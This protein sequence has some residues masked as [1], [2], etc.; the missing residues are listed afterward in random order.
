MIRPL[1][2]TLTLFCS[3]LYFACQSE[4][5][6]LKTKSSTVV[7]DMSDNHQGSLDLSALEQNCF[8]CHGADKQ[9]GKVRPWRTSLRRLEATRAP[10]VKKLSK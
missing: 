2:L 8:K 7:I 1:L 10:V 4:K 5:E 9:K 3:G 6:A